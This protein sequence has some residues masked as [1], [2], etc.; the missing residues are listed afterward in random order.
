MR[1]SVYECVYVPVN[2]TCGSAAV[3]GSDL[4][5]M[6]SGTQFAQNLCCFVCVHLFALV[7]ECQRVCQYA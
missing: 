4:Q 5:P 1:V 3:P 6:F 2:R 7:H